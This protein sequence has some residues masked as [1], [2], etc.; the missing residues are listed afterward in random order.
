MALMDETVRQ[1]LTDPN[2]DY[3]QLTWENS[4]PMFEFWISRFADPDKACLAWI[5]LMSKNA[6][7][8]FNRFGSAVLSNGYTSSEVTRNKN[9]DNILFASLFDARRGKKNEVEPITDFDCDAA[10]AQHGNWPTQSFITVK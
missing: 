4:L 10:S 7:S 9:E 6:Q 5:R 2:F 8:L 3:S 1:I